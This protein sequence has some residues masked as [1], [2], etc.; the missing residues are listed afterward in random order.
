MMRNLMNFLDLFKSKKQREAETDEKFAAELEL[1]SSDSDT[2][3]RNGTFLNSLDELEAGD[4]ELNETAVKSE[5][6]SLLR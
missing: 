1:D 4:I 2:D 5:K 6:T 3:F